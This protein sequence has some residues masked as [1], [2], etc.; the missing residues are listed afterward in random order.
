M[1]PVQTLGVWLHSKSMAQYTCITFCSEELRRGELKALQAQSGKLLSAL[2]AAQSALR[3]QLECEAKLRKVEDDSWDLRKRL[4]EANM[5]LA[6][7]R[8][9]TQELSHK[10]G[11]AV[12]QLESSTTK[13]K[14]GPSFM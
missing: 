12:I 6:S 3:R 14:T 5:E 4:S 10:L 9:S 2:E 13:G 7:L 11:N 1:D 8:R